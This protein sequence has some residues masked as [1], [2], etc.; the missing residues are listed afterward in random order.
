S[1]GWLFGVRR[2]RCCEYC[3]CLF[4]AFGTRGGKFEGKLK[5]KR[6]KIRK[7]MEGKLMPTLCFEGE[8]FFHGQHRWGYYKVNKS[9]LFF[10]FYAKLY[11]CRFI[12]KYYLETWKDT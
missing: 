6:A 9:V 8:M 4:P 12:I 1:V 10:W 3:H 7:E 5:G 11:S 2:S